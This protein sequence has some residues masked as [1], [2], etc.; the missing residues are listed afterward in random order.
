LRYKSS[1]VL[2]GKEEIDLVFY[3]CSSIFDATKV[4]CQCE[5]SEVS[6]VLEVSEVSEVSHFFG[7]AVDSVKPSTGRKK[8]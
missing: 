6:E 1:N 7:A 4:R 5:I 8:V 2:I 3:Y